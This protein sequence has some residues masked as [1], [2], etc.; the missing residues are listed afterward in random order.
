MALDAVEWV[1]AG[2][3]L[4][5]DGDLARAEPIETFAA[6]ELARRRKKIRKRG[7]DLADLNPQARHRVRIAVKKLRYATE[8]F[9]PLYEGRKT[10]KR[11]KAFLSALEDLQERLGELNDLAVSQEAHPDWFRIGV[12]AEDDRSHQEATHLI[13]KHEAE[14]ADAAL[15]PALKAYRAFAEAKRFWH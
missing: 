6:A 13:V 11:N 14:R 12:G 8:F 5:M 4:T 10:S 9:S 7:A 2:P 1:E 3:W 15:K